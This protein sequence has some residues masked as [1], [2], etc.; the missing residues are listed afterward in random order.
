MEQSSSRSDLNSFVHRIINSLPAAS[1][2][3]LTRLTI[4][5]KIRGGGGG[6]SFRFS[7]FKPRT[8]SL[9]YK[10]WFY[11]ETLFPSLCPSPSLLLSLPIIALQGYG[12]SFNHGVVAAAISR[13]QQKNRPSPFEHAFFKTNSLFLPSSLC[14]LL[15]LPLSLPLRVTKAS[16]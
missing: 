4:A 2:G 13:L 8:F 7:A 16:F 5:F 12:L 1:L 6:D 9:T 3:A 15:S 14:L 10:K 11:E